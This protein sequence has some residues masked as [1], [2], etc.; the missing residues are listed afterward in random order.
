MMSTFKN[1]WFRDPNEEV[2]FI[3]ETAVRIRAGMM[4]VIPLF[5][6]LTLFD[7]LYTSPWIVDAA[8]VE[9]TYEV[10]EASQIIYS[11]QMTQRVYDYT[12]Q[13]ALLFYGLFEL[14]VGMTAWSS[15]FSPTI[16]IA[17]FLARNKTPVWKPIAP[18]RFAWGLGISL[19]SFCLVFFNPDT[20]ANGVNSLFNGEWLPTTTNYIPYEI[21]V[22]LVWVCLGMVWLEAVLGFC[23]GC[24]IHALL[25]KLGMINEPCYACNNIDWDAIRARHEAKS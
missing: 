16:Q 14:L 7:V 13:T 11:G 5:M 23:L 3:N 21:P 8:T 19:A 12:A 18:K 20:F 4:I 10:T 25:V 9:D 15:R 22:T 17:S 2:L 1:T 24:K 6:A